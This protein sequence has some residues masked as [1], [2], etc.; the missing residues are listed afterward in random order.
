MYLDG[1]SFRWGRR[2]FARVCIRINLENNLPSGVW[3]DG[4]AGRFFQKVEYEKID[5]L[6]FR[7]G[8]IGHDSSNCAESSSAQA[9]QS[10]D[11]L[12]QENIACGQQKNYGPWIHVN[13]KNRRSQGKINTAAA[14]QANRGV[15]KGDVSL[16]H[17][18]ADQVQV[19]ANLRNEKISDGPKNDLLIANQ[20]NILSE[21]GKIDYPCVVDGSQ[22]HEECSSKDFSLVS[23]PVH[24]SAAEIGV[25]VMGGLAGS[26]LKHKGARELRSLGPIEADHRKRKVE[27]AGGAR[28]KEAS[29]YLKE[30]LRDSGAFFVGIVETKLANVDRGDVNRIIGSDWDFFQHPAVGLS[31]GILVAWDRSLVSFE[32]VV[33]SSQVVVGRL[34]SKSLGCWNVATVYGSRLCLER[35][36]LWGILADCLVGDSPSIVGGDFNCVLGKEDKRGGKR[37]RLSKGPR[38]MRSFMTN[39]DFHDLVSI[40]PAYT[41]CNNKEGASRI[42]E[43]LDRC[44]LNSAALQ[45]I[46]FAKVRHL[47]R[48]A[49]DH[50]PI[51]LNLVDKL[52]FK[53]KI[54][55]FEDTWRS[56]PASWNIVL[57]SWRRANFGSA[58]EILKKKL[59]RTMK[60]LFFWNK[61][62]CKNLCLLK[63]QLKKEIL[64]LQLDESTG[65]ETL[66]LLRYKVHELNITLKRLSTWWNQRAKARWLDEGDTNSNFFHKYASARRYGNSIWQ[67]KDEDNS[68]IEDAH[69]IEEVFYRF[70]KKK[71][72]KSTVIFGKAVSR[73]TKL[74]VSRKLGFKVVKEMHYLGIK[75]MMRRLGLD[76]FQDLLIS[77]FEKLNGWGKKLLSLAGRILL[78]KSSLL[79]MP[80]Y[81]IT[82]SL[83]PKGVL[84]ELDKVCRD[85]ILNKSNG[86]RGMH[87]VAWEE[88]CKPRCDG[89]MGMISPAT[90]AGSLRARLAWNLLEKPDSLFHRNMIAK[91]GKNVVNGECR[92]NASNA[93]KILID[94]GLHLKDITKWKVG[95]GV[96]I[97]VV[98]DTWLLDRCLRLWPTFVDFENLEGRMVQQFLN[99]DGS[100]NILE[101]KKF[102]HVELVR[103]ILQVKVHVDLGGDQLE[104]RCQHSGKSITAMAY[105][106]KL[107]KKINDDD[108]G[109]SKW[110]RS[111]K[112]YPRV[113]LFWWRLSKSAI[114]TN[115]FLMKRGLL[116]DSSCPRGCNQ[117]ENYNHVMAQCTALHKVLQKLRDWGFTVPFFNNLDSCLKELRR[118]SVDHGNIVKMYCI[119]VFLSWKNRNEVKH[120][121]Q[122]IDTSMVASNVLSLF[123]INN[124]PILDCWGANLLR[125][126]LNSWHPPPLD[127]IKVN[128]DASLLRTNL[129]GIGGVFRDHKGRLIMAF[130]R[131]M[132]H[133]D[134]AQ[135]EM[136]AV[137]SLQEYIQDWMLE[138][139]GLIIEEKASTS[140]PLSPSPLPTPPSLTTI[141]RH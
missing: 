35:S 52:H 1:N 92:Q 125:E 130:G 98:N 37:F 122:P 63:E 89:G 141:G 22:K 102:F 96:R 111:L 48:V 79:T 62:K 19:V 30:V 121:K 95:D 16:L 44:L 6:C 124:T 25:D 66:A 114:P 45:L 49:S 94:G 135:L 136:E 53:S 55:R 28:K 88:M 5:L 33:H 42:W 101:L 116:L 118:L 50:C 108:D 123:K 97:N 140:I 71:W 31:G 78:A 107:K 133:W 26:I 40:G 83:V 29:L 61:D 86:K 68:L 87:F 17:K 128:V 64:E 105:E 132:F 139:K 69:Q 11:K 67:I 93:W 113:E 119:T 15:D 117:E 7:C 100:W 112:L 74:K 103:L 84:H 138:C 24:Y 10:V 18:E 115:L 109:F 134:V 85:F 14:E 27:A 58:G 54:I 12:Q 80:N 39:S 60:N 43:R 38:E 21:E 8:K 76:D 20:F 91:Y 99:T 82:H 90:R 131:N 34:S 59:S 70:F 120:G 127:W 13:F 106:E 72:S 56:Y 23:E 75:I 36:S 47:A 129:A 104:L 77:V 46:P 65:K 2:E 81:I 126:S 41:W 9:V 32:V 110:L 51:V 4:I 137:V 3:V 57:K 73:A